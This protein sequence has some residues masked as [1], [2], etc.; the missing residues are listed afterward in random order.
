MRGIRL[1]VAITWCALGVLWC[2][3]CVGADGPVDPVTFCADVTE[4]P[5]A[6]CEALLA[7]YTQTDGAHWA[8]S[9]NWF[10]TVTP[11]DWYGVTVTQGHVTSI[12]LSANGL[13]GQLPAELGDLTA[14]DHLV[15]ESNRLSGPIPAALGD[16][17]A[18]QVLMLGGCELT[19]GIPTALGDLTALTSLELRGNP[20]GGT[21][22][23]DLANLTSLRW[24]NLANMGV[25]GPIP[26]RYGELAA[27]EHLMLNGNRLNGAIPPELGELAALRTLELGGNALTGPIPADL[28]G[29][30]QLNALVLHDNQL[31]GAIPPALGGLAN[32]YELSLSGN[33]LRGP[34]PPALGDLGNLVYCYLGSN[35]LSGPIPAALGDLD[36]LV[37]LDLGGNRLDGAIPAAL[38]DLD[39]LGALYLDHNALSGAVPAA[40]CDLR[41]GFLDIGYNAL[42]APSADARALLDAQDPDWSQTQTVAPAN[43]R[44]ASWDG[45]TARFTWTP[46]RYTGDG[47]GYEIA[48]ATQPGGP[49]ALVDTTGGKSVGEYTVPSVP[50]GTTYWTVRTSTPAHGEQQNDLWSARSPEIM[51]PPAVEGQVAL[52]PLI[53]GGRPSNTLYGIVLDPPSPASLANY[54]NVSVHLHYAVAWD[55]ELRITAQALFEGSRVGG[56]HAV[57]VVPGRGRA[58]PTFTHRNGTVDQVRLRMEDA[59]TGDIVYEETLDVSF[60]FGEAS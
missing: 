4:I 57:T 7:L 47:G 48:Y 21:L 58:T 41:V 20:L 40:V 46:I 22:P 11:S 1:F 26:A 39:A 36:S 6:E 24:A 45:A 38:G 50:S 5:G 12:S 35:Q 54:T 56:Y 16:L 29:L 13:V 31:D 55:N 42:W 25:S 43:V 30:A 51:I 32:L 52:I 23:S 27:L 44:L 28:G 9:T 3:A 14:L 53:E 59:T 60:A 34:I 19:G 2:P 17:A 15:L 8:V 10:Q 33:E 37:V 49:Y 18:L